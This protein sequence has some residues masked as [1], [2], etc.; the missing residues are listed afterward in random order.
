MKLFCKHRYESLGF[1]QETG[2]L[3]T[4]RYTVH[5]IRCIHCGKEKE[6]TGE[7][8]HFKMPLHKKYFRCSKDEYIECVPNKCKYKER[9]E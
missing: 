5:K 4:V 7:T 8:W 2:G 3:F 1:R 6:V 9:E